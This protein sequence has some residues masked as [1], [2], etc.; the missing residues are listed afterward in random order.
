MLVNRNQSIQAPGRPTPLVGVQVQ[1]ADKKHVA[2]EELVEAIGESR[3]ILVRAKT[4]F[5]LTLFPDTISLDRTK[6]TI[7]HR[8]FFKAGDVLSIG[9]EDILNVAATVGP[10]FG[11]ITITTRFFDQDNKPY[12]VDHF[13][14]ADALKIKRIAQGYVIAKQKGVDCSALSNPELTKLL[15]ELGKVAPAEKV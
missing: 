12:K 2:E 1:Q 13:T 9:I 10:F 14:R 4:V 11:S 6:L 7:T 3:D 15:D 8:D 5:P